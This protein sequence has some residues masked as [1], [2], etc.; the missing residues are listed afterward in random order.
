MDGLAERIGVAPRHHWLFDR[1]V[2]SLIAE[3][4]VVRRDGALF[5]TR[6]T[7]RQSA[8]DDR[9]RSSCAKLGYGAE[10]Y[11]FFLH[12]NGDLRLLL[13]DKLTVQELLFNG[14]G[15]AIAES[16][17]RENPMSRY[18]NAALAEAV[19]QHV[20]KSDRGMLAFIESSREHYQLMASMMFLLSSSAG[21]ARPGAADFRAG[22]NRIC[23]TQAE[24]HE[25]LRQADFA[26]R[27][28][29]PDAEHDP[30]AVL[31]HYLYIAAPTNLES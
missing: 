1:W 19:A 12:C 27:A 28:T 6:D 26:P 25:Q 11:D 4:Y 8:D 15:F 2:A 10:P 9:M 24:W 13:G 14:S 31:E 16:A 29:V 18:L 20:R 22:E 7:G 5:A 3:G 30:A 17:C 23:L 21:H